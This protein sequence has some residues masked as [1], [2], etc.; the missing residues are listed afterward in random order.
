MRN[1][2]L[3]KKCFKLFNISALYLKNGILACK[4]CHRKEDYIKVVPAGVKLNIKE[5]LYG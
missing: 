2:K 3:C 5:E 1:K 4:Y